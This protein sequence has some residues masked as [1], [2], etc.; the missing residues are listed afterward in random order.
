M[1]QK[2]EPSKVLTTRISILLFGSI[3]NDYELRAGGIIISMSVRLYLSDAL[4]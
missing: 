3:P 4:V 1:E 2:E